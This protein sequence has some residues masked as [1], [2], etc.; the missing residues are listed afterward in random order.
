MSDK[1]LTP[2]CVAD[3][4]SNILNRVLVIYEMSQY[5]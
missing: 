4:Q 1:A 2:G 5:I 3:E